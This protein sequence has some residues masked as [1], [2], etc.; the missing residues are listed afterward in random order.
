MVAAQV[1]VLLQTGDIVVKSFWP[2]LFI[3]H[4]TN[5]VRIEYAVII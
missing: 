1:F 3:P 4:C 2:A 5:A